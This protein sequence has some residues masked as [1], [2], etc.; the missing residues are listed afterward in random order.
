MTECQTIFNQL[1]AYLIAALLLT[2][3]SIKEMLYLYLTMSLVVVSSVLVRVEDGVQ[4]PI[5]NSSMVLWDI[6]TRYP[7]VKKI[8][9]ALLISVQ[10]LQPYFQAHSITALLINPE[11][12]LTKARHLRKVGQ[13]GCGALRI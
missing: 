6:E 5:Y 10:W 11:V 2:K 1:R 8:A 12:G 13:V 4:R 9:Y 7:R 3:P